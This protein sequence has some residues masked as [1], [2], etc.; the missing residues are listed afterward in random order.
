MRSE[1]DAPGVSLD[2]MDA[3]AER[4]R[5]GEEAVLMPP[6]GAYATYS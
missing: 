2:L 5:M 3:Q 1:T 6:L 4:N